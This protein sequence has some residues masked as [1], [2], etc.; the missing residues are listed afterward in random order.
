MIQEK[1]GVYKIYLSPM[2]G[3]D[4]PTTT[5]I[6][7]YHHMKVELELMETLIFLYWFS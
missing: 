2:S 6:V 1:E 7:V 5:K 3:S 4:I